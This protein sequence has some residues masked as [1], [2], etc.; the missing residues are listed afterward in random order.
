[1]STGSTLVA[2]SVMLRPYR[3]YGVA[4]AV[5]VIVVPGVVVVV[6][7]VVVVVQWV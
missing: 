2:R 7:W 5:V 6:P 1:M 3:S 4:V